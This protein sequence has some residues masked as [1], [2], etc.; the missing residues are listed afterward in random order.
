MLITLNTSVIIQ[1]LT[2]FANLF[3]LGI[4]ALISIVSINVKFALEHQLTVVDCLESKDETLKRETLDL[5]FKMTNGNNVDVIVAKLVHYLKNASDSHF[6]KDLVSKIIQISEQF[7]PNQEWYIKTMNTVL[8]HGSEF[9]DA[10]SFTNILKLIDENFTM[11]QG[12]GEFLVS[13]YSEDLNKADIS[14]ILTKVKPFL[15]VRIIINIRLN[16]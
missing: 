9:V 7:A 16:R 8:E 2:P 1:K 15:F 14:D 12:F 13:S 10:D 6:R 3:C 4:N 5:L 11:N